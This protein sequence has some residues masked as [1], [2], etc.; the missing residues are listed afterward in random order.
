M[1]MP[2]DVH[3][4]LVDALRATLDACGPTEGAKLPNG[5][6]AGDIPWG[7]AVSPEL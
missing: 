4:A 5:A 3:T 7:P 2:D 1:P 6:Y